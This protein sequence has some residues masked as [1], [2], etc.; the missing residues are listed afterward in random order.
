MNMEGLADQ[1]AQQ[2][3]LV[4][5]RITTDEEVAWLRGVYDDIFDARKHEVRGYLH[6]TRER[7][8]GAV[9]SRPQVFGPEQ[10]VP[11]L[12]G[13]ICMRNARG[14]ATSLLGT[15]PTTSGTMMILKPPHLGRAT[16]WHQDEAY[17]R[18]GTDLAANG[19]AV[20]VALDDA[21]PQSGCMR[22]IAGSHRDGVVGHHLVDETSHMLEANIV[23]TSAAVECPLAPGGA[24]VHHCRTIHS[25]GENTSPYPRRAWILTFGRAST[26]C[27]RQVDR[28]WLDE[29]ERR[30][31]RGLSGAY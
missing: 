27:A 8:D 14:L 20:W 11:E 22:F 16:C 31:G 30:L 2:G 28:P 13:T 15:A 6:Y 26:P 23:D 21:T 5:D 24:T 19:V 4:L 17:W 10:D 1:F 29:V 7:E 18:V 3:Y 12:L 25:A 9:E